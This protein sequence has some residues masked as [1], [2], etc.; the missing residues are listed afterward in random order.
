MKYTA[1]E[2]TW[3][4]K[5]EA[6]VFFGQW[7]RDAIPVEVVTDSIQHGCLL[8]LISKHPDAEQ[9]IG[10]GIYRFEIRSNPVFQNQNTFYLTRKDGTDADFSFRSCISGKSKTAWA[11]FCS[12]ARNAISDQIIVFKTAAFLSV[13][14][15]LCAL[16]GDHVTWGSCHVDHVIEFSELLRLFVQDYSIDIESEVKASADLQILSEF[17]SDHVRANWVDYHRRH[18]ELRITTAAANLARNKKA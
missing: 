11:M 6:G 5:K 7:L 18:A 1:G 17:S 16:T 2:F 8:D 10:C 15:P 9:K 3:K 4:S 13:T 12:A 14:D